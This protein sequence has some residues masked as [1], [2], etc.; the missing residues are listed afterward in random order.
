MYG[1]EAPDVP[2]GNT[3]DKETIVELAQAPVDECYFGIADERNIYP[4]PEDEPCPAG[5]DEKRN[6]SYLWGLT[7]YTDKNVKRLYFGSGANVFCIGL[8]NYA[9]LQIPLALPG[10]WACQNG[11][12]ND[13]ELG[14]Q[15]PPSIYIYDIDTDQMAKPSINAKAE[16]IRQNTIGLRSDGQYEGIVFLAGPNSNKAISL[17]AFNGATGELLD[18]TS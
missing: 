3:K 8:Q 4:K 14:D 15:R 5:S 7:A 10:S 16:M 13:K 6:E 18:A 9:A 17:F 12:R 11:F 1:A 2:V